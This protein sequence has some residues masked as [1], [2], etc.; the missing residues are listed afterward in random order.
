MLDE[1][2]IM[3]DGFLYQCLY[4]IAHINKFEETFGFKAR[5]HADYFY[6]FNDVKG[7]IIIAGCRA[8]K[9]VKM[10]EPPPIY[11]TNRTWLWNFER[12]MAEEFFYPNIYVVNEKTEQ[13]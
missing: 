5:N 9:A 1:P 6:T 2:T 11:N 8:V 13:P 4:G 10:S 7:D 3:P 12:K